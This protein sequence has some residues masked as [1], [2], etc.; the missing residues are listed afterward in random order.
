MGVLV[1][2]QT[3][4]VVSPVEHMDQISCWRQRGE[5]SRLADE[6]PV[7]TSQVFWGGGEMVP[8]QCTEAEPAVKPVGREGE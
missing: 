2:C 8:L 7:G 1:R 6:Q 4:S 3:P 5:W